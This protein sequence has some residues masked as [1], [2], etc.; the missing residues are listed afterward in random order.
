M[1]LIVN[2]S[3]FAKRNRLLKHV[4]HRR[5]IKVFIFQLQINLTYVRFVTP[6]GIIHI[7]NT[8][9]KNTYSSFEG[10]RLRNNKL[11]IIRHY[12]SFLHH[13]HSSVSYGIGK[14][15]WQRVFHRVFRYS[16]ISC[17]GLDYTQR[18]PYTLRSLR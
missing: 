6:H 3:L 10:R 11:I 7:W 12:I 15:I 9:L 17:F 13:C 1:A 5:Q 2:I 14:F 8:R 18:S 16:L 4:Y